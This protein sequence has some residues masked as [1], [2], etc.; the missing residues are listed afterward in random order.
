VILGRPSA[1]APGVVA[2]TGSQGR[3]DRVQRMLGYEPGPVSDLGGGEYVVGHPVEHLAIAPDG[4]V[5]LAYPWEITAPQLGG[6]L[7]RLVQE[8]WQG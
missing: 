4:T 2:L 7:T 1:R 5:R 3:I 6:D 8:G